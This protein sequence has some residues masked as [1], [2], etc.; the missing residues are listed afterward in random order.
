MGIVIPEKYGGL[1]LEMT[2]LLLAIEELAA[3]GCGMGGAWYLI[4]TEAFGALKIVRHGTEK[5][6][7]KYLPKLA[8]GEMEFCMALNRTGGGNQY[9]RNQNDSG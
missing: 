8:K 6:K 1:A 5:Q 3:N 7:E 4:L 2:E 9:S